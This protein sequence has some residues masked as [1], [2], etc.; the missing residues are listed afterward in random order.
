MEAYGIFL[1]NNVLDGG[2]DGRLSFGS[3]SKSSLVSVEKDL[4]KMGDH[5]GETCRVK[6]CLVAAT[7]EKARLHEPCIRSEDR[8]LRDW[9]LRTCASVGVMAKP[10]DF[11]LRVTRDISILEDA[12]RAGPPYLGVI[13]NIPEQYCSSRHYF[14][15]LYR[16]RRRVSQI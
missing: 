14:S 15:M 3:S 11:S 13:I 2:G 1:T 10:P 5:D 16:G 6:D 8:A 4:M 7:L 9:N 12:A